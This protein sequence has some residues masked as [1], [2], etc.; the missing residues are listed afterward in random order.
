MFL[1][2]KKKPE[3]A[4]VPHKK[5]AE[6]S[7]APET[8]VQESKKMKIGNILIIVSSVLFIYDAIAFQL[9]PMI[10]SVA[11]GGTPIMT[12]DNWQMGVNLVVWL[13]YPVFA[14]FEVFACF[15]GFAWVYK[16]GRI[17]GM[18][19]LICILVVAALLIDFVLFI[20]SFTSSSSRVTFFLSFFL[21][22]AIGIVYLVGWILT[23]DDFEY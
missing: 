12:D 2:R 11:S 14:I 17:Q 4:V 6:L 20:T 22:V 23:K 18:T 10:T 3:I 16:K 1:R 5:E 8:P 21:F 7:P 15:G 19:P 13:L 9:Y